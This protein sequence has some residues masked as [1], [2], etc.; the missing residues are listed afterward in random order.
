MPQGE[1]DEARQGQARQRRCGWDAAG[2]GAMNRLSHRSVVVGLRGA[3]VAS[4]VGV[5]VLSGAGPALAGPSPWWHLTALTRP[6]YL[7][8]GEATDEVQEIRVSGET[9]LYQLRTPV[10]CDCTKGETIVLAAASPAEMQSLL[11]SEVYGL[12]NVTVT[13]GQ[14]VVGGRSYRVTF[15][16]GLEAQWVAQLEA[17]P[18]EKAN[19]PPVSITELTRGRPDGV[20]VVNAVNLGDAGA[21]PTVQPITLSD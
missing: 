13:A 18:V 16:G 4:I 14:P 5:V 6:S 2:R 21:D 10:G 19:S 9:G 17:A 8:P 15:V 7:Q 1:R 20:I 12:G 3:L 11:E